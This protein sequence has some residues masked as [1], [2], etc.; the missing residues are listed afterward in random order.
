MYGHSCH[1]VKSIFHECD[2]KIIKH[3]AK[4]KVVG[5][6][7]MPKIAPLNTLKLFFGKMFYFFV[8]FMKNTFATISWFFFKNKTYMV[9]TT[10]YFLIVRYFNIGLKKTFFSMLVQKTFFWSRIWSKNLQKTKIVIQKLFVEWFFPIKIVRIGFWEHSVRYQRTLM[11]PIFCSILN[12]L[13]AMNSNPVISAFGLVRSS[14][15]NSQKGK[16]D[17]M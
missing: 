2:K 16:R 14:I 11:S 1:L 15:W 4:K 7:K 8:T 3:F 17:S 12:C 6:S 13:F 9:S 5:C 10:V